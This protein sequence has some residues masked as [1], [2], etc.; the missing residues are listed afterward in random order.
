MTTTQ[1]TVR[2]PDGLIDRLDELLPWAEQSSAF[3]GAS[4][5][6][7]SDVIRQAVRLGVEKMEKQRKRE[8]KRT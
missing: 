8:K 6:R 4:T 1:I 7:R 2:L 3:G 5:V